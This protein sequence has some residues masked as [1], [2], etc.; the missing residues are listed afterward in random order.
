MS[1]SL[2]RRRPVDELEGHPP[3]PVHLPDHLEHQ[4]LVEIGVEQRADR[5]DRCG[6]CD[7]RRGLRYP[8]PLCD[9]M[10]QSRTRQGR[11]APRR[12]RRY[13]TNHDRNRFRRRRPRA[14][15]ARRPVRHLPRRHH[16]PERRLRRGQA[17]RG[18]RLQGRRA[19]RRP[20]AASRPTIP[21]TGRRAK[22][23]A[24]Q[25]IDGVRGLRLRRR[26]ERLVRRHADP[27]LSRALR[28]RAG[29]GGEGRALR[30][31]DAR[32]RS[33]SSS[34]CSASSEVAARFDGTVA[35]HDSCSGLRELGVKAQPRRLLAERRG[36]DARRTRRG[37]DLLRLRRPVRRQVRRTVERRSSRAR[38]TTS[39]ERRPTRCSPAT[40]AAS[41]TWPASFSATARRSRR[42]TSPR[43]SPAWP[44]D[45]RSASRQ[46]ESRSDDRASRPRPGSRRT[47]TRR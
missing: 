35:Y 4:Q 45:R 7:C 11:S 43:C 17:A 2:H 31:K 15:A 26:A 16:A 12:S 22:A 24:R 46:T 6:T 20:A 3:L 5:S 29:H 32:A 21:A 27:A 9:L 47:S 1:A 40:S 25:A 18:R 30:R 37:R 39:A 28:R 36:A 13:P 23:L 8:W 44:T 33:A 34:T 14:S 19:R 38:P 41:S 42:A 10:G